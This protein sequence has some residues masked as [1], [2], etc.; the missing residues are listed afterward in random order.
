[1]RII[2]NFKDFYDKACSHDQDRDIQYIRHRVAKNTTEHMGDEFR[3]GF[4]GVI[5]N[6]IYIV[7]DGVKSF[8]YDADKYLEARAK[9]SKE[10]DS[11]VYYDHVFGD[12]KDVPRTIVNRSLHDSYRIMSAK[13]EL[14][15]DLSFFT[16]KYE[17]KNFD[18]LFAKYSIGQKVENCPIFVISH[19]QVVLNENL[20]KYDFMKV[21]DPYTAYQELRVYV[22]NMAMPE[23]PMPIIP[24]DMR[25]HTHGFDKWSFRKEP[26]GK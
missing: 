7:R 15:R 1:M 21:K 23:K 13:D 2:S 12:K 3:I 6:G 8:Y 10:N 17:Y 24:N 16:F 25:I 26:T 20:S 4:C 19:E 14:Q 9:F 5:Y 11:K 18:Y 22:S